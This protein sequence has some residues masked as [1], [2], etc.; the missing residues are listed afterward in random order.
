MTKELQHSAI[1]K[2]LWQ[3]NIRLK[4]DAFA[5]RSRKQ[6]AKPRDRGVATI[7]G[8]EKMGAETF[9]LLRF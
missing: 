8:D 4:R 6:I 2:I 1:A 3:W 9:S 7:G 5:L